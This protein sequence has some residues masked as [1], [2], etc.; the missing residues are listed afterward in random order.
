M[1]SP[2][3]S[4]LAQM[5]REVDA[6]DVERARMRQPYAWRRLRERLGE[7]PAADTPRRM[8]VIWRW[9]GLAAVGALVALLALPAILGIGQGGPGVTS[10]SALS[11]QV[12]VTAFYAPAAEADVVWLT[13]LSPLPAHG[14]GKRGI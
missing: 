13:G 6:A 10:A 11:P 3:D 4:T 8:P 12:Q 2:D 14:L 5:L 9:V 1:N 7:N